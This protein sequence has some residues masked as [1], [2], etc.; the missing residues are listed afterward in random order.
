MR[1]ARIRWL[2]FRD[3]TRRDPDIA[4][5]LW[6][7]RGIFSPPLK[8][9]LLVLQP[10]PFCNIRCDYC[11]LP[12]RDSKKRMP[13]DVVEAATRNIIECDLLGPELCVVWHAGEPLVMPVEFYRAAFE[14]IAMI[15]G[16]RAS[17]IHSIQTNG[18]LISQQWCE[19]FR[20]YNIRI[21]VSLDGPAF[22]HDR[23]RRTRSGK[24]THA[25]VMHGVELLQQ[26]ALPFHTI[27]VV[28]RDT[29]NHADEFYG[30]FENAG[31]SDI[32]IN[33]DEKEGDNEC[34]SLNGEEAR[35][36]AFMQRLLD[37]SLAPAARVHI[38]ELDRA[39]AHI[40]R[41]FGSYRLGGVTYPYNEQVMPF[42][43]TSVDCDG[44]FS[45]FSPELL[46]QRDA[47]YQ[48]YVFGNV[49]YDSLDSAFFQPGFVELY[50]QILEGIGLCARECQYYSLCGG[51]AP[52]NKAYENEAFNSA[53]TSYCRNVVQLPI[54]LMLTHLESQR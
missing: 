43:I 29:L 20:D 4:P 50:R 40:C 16:G 28:T 33:I 47:R 23:H 2:G 17:V 53:A 12:D 11:Y 13:L 26:N 8:V 42:A 31:I 51:G 19:L 39:H 22:I 49:L 46:G 21:G 6:F 7:D 54:R 14:R 3:K 37:L 32:G 10:T 52:A 24:G 35:F 1:I 41:E 44:N 15:V 34:S 18:M 27:S 30:F 9:R 38:R 48:D 25:Q 5:S 45:T 36:A